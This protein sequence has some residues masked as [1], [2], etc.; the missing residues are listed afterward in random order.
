MFWVC[1]LLT[2]THLEIGQRGEHIKGVCGRKSSNGKQRK[3]PGYGSGTKL[4]FQLWGEHDQQRLVLA[5]CGA[6]CNVTA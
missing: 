2:A 6:F 1:H 4:L 5:P 3:S